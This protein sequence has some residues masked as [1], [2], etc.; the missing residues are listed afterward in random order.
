M[1]RWLL[2]ITTILLLSLPGIAAAQD[3]VATPLPTPDPT[4]DLQ[5]QLDEARLLLDKITERGQ[6]SDRALDIAFNLL[7]IFEAIGFLV[8]VGGGLLAAFG[9]ARLFSAQAEL[10]KAR[11]RFEEEIE[12]KERELDEMKEDLESTIANSAS[13][14][15]RELSQATLALSLLPLGE[16]QYRAQD[17]QGAMD[18]YRRALELD[19]QNPVTHLRLGYVCTQSGLLDDARAHLT[20]A[21]EIEPGFAP[22]LAALGYVYRRITEKMEASIEREEMLNQAEGR[23]LEALRQSP[24]L[25][26][27]DGESW[28]GSLG[29]LYRRRNQIEDAIRA[30]ERAAEVTPHSS[31]PFSNLALLYM[32]T[33]N[34][35]QM[36]AT[37]RR[38]ERLARGETQADVDNYWA[39]AD[40]LTAQLALGKVS[41]AEEALQSVLDI[42]PVDSPY[43]LELLA[44]TLERLTQ[45]L[46]GSRSAPHIAPFIE[47]VR[48]EIARRRELQSNG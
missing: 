15:H 45:A 18:T 41:Q 2:L 7:G 4:A 42:A 39:H 33:S 43:V 26:D 12:T 14:Q 16:R 23:L 32:Q 11:E 44:D 24:K 9:V 5:A 37:Y 27:D 36:L 25:V 21:L 10:Q 6:D 1:R 38:V 22:A 19:D 47:R 20:R 31:Y 48:A 40:L 46:G 28:W 3:P 35:D 8:T 34:R 13:L 17:F 29:G 30:Y